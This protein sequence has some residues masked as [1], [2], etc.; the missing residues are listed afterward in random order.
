VIRC[1]AGDANVTLRYLE[2]DVNADCVVN[3]Q[4]QQLI[5]FRWGARLGSLLYNSR[6]D[7]EPAAPK[8]GD[9]DIDAKDL[10]V[11]FGRHE[12]TCADP[13]PLQAP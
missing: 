2:G 4:D 11:V 8:K 7:L 1:L 12:S 6:Y 13:H 10:Q 3:V 5:A 9:G